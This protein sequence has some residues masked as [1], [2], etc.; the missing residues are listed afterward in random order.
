MN[1]KY[2]I[3]LLMILPVMANAQLKGWAEKIGN[4]VKHK[5]AA[6][7]DSKIDRA[8]DKTLD[9][10]EGKGQPVIK[11]EM[12][13]KEAVDSSAPGSKMYAKYDF[14]PGE[15]VI[16]SNDFASDNM[17]ELATGWNSNGTGAVITLD[18]LKG[19]WLQLYQNSTY[20][21]DNKNAF[22]ENFTVE[23]DLVMRRV[24][25]KA[26]FP[27]LIWGVLSSGSM[28]PGDNSLLKDHAAV[29]A[30]EMSMQPSDHIRSTMQ[31]QTVA[32][33]S[34]HFKSDIQKRGDLLIQ[35]N[36]VIHMAMQVQ[37]E[38]VRIWFGEEK[39]YDVPRAMMPATN[40]NQLYFIVKRYGGPE[41][42]VG[43]AVSNLK[44]AKG[45][46]DTRHKLVEEGRF[47][48]TGI[49][50]GVNSYSL[51]PESN[52]VL[53][54]ISSVLIKNP[55]LKIKIIGHTDNDGNDAANLELSKKRAAAVKQALVADF[56]VDALR[57]ETD[58][59]GESQ[60]VSDNNTKE[61]KANNRRV[62]FVKQ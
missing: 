37:K 48:T 3:L 62:E 22:T 50:F 31:F 29:F 13:K 35:F 59:A 61:G 12:K 6:R 53:R 36:K 30:T 40:I 56:N 19:N 8:I 25:P 58:G 33:R 24:N 42:E 45:L 54:E 5:S 18:A 49:L 1:T 20:L 16:Y 34:S 32:G 52:G 43:Y 26:A 23:F 47:S 15:Q 14:V 9:M 27:E 57:I 39:V 51:L 46:P 44:I 17:G 41:Q 10:A 4:K 7:A 21:S 55:E 60:P 38:R 28:A 11:N 2:F